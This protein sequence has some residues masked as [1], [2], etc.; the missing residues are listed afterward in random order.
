MMKKTVLLLFVSLTIVFLAATFTTGE[1]ARPSEGLGVTST[2][3]EFTPTPLPTEELTAV[4]TVQPTDTPAP[5]VPTATKAPRRSSNPQPTPEALP[6]MGMGEERAGE[7]HLDSPVT[8]IQIP[9]LG[10]DRAVIGVPLAGEGWD[11]SGLGMEVGWL[12]TSS[13]PMLG[14]NTVLV[15]HL[16][17]KGGVAGPFVR[18]GDLVE[19]MEVVVSAG[20]VDYHYRVTGR[21]VTGPD[22]I[23]AQ[24]ASKSPR[25]TLVTCYPPSWDIKTQE[26]RRRLVVVAEPIKVGP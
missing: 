9:K 4:P 25:L 20:G 6:A 1:A 18:L 14:G 24:I 22:D 16:D 5:I 21:T 11:I 10:V 2:P 23:T 3:A 13:Q 17:M 12:E 7:I 26:Y 15:G 8:R 19:G